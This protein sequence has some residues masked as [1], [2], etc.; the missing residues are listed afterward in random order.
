MGVEHFGIL[1]EDKQ[2]II[3]VR[4]SSHPP[5]EEEHERA[6]EALLQLFREAPKLLGE[7]SEEET[8][9]SYNSIYSLT[10]IAKLVEEA[11][12]PTYMTAVLYLAFCKMFG[13]KPRI[14]N[15]FYLFPEEGARKRVCILGER[16]YR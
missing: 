2:T 8:V 12:S 9:T 3:A 7:L 10:R 13:I 16:C 15:E 4:L 14:V 6:A 5:D 1:F 11:V